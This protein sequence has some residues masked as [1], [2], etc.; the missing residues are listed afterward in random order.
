MSQTTGVGTGGTITGGM[1]VTGTVAEGTPGPLPARTAGNIGAGVT[2]TETEMTTV[3]GIAALLRE[4]VT[5][6][7]GIDRIHNP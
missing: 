3:A 4:K 2:E 5:T 6:I 7:A 1:T